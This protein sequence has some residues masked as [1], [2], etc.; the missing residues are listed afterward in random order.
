M[1]RLG[2]RLIIP[3][4]KLDLGPRKT[5]LLTVTG[6]KTGRPYTTPVNL[7]ERDG[8][9]Y[10]VAPYGEVSWVRNARAIGEVTLRRGRQTRKHRI[11]EMPPPE[12]APILADY[13]RE[14]LITRPYF[15]VTPDSNA[16]VFEREATRHPV[17]GLA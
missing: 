3:A 10:L 16:S 15:N 6:R 13:W 1:R 12:A 5:H 4:V 9:Q 17:F 11:E 8:R 14:N 2:N 7:V